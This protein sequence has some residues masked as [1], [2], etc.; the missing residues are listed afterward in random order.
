MNVFAKRYYKVWFVVLVVQ[1]VALLMYSLRITIGNLSQL[2]PP[3]LSSDDTTLSVLAASQQ[4]QLTAAASSTATKDSIPP[5]SI[6]VVEESDPMHSEM[7]TDLLNDTCLLRIASSIR[8][9]WTVKA[10]STWCSPTSSNNTTTSTENPSHQQQHKGLLLTKVPK[11]ASSTVAAIVLQIQHQWHCSVQWQH[12]RA[13]DLFY[14]QR[15]KKHSFLMAPVRD[16]K[17]RAMSSVYFH[18]ISFHQQRAD[19]TKI[20]SDNFIFN[21]LSKIPSNYI[22]DYLSLLHTPTAAEY[23][24]SF[25]PNNSRTI[26]AT[27][28]LHLQ[29]QKQSQHQLLQQQTAHVRQHIQTIVNEYD[30]LLVADQMVESLIVMSILTDIPLKSFVV[31]SSKVSGNWYYTNQR[32]IRLLSPVWT[33]PIVSYFESSSW[34][35][36]HILDRLLYMVAHHSLQATIAAH[37]ID[38][39]QRY[40]LFRTYQQQVQSICGNGGTNTTTLS[41]RCSDNGTV[42]PFPTKHRCYQRDFGCGYECVERALAGL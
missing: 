1:V 17:T 5:F 42:L 28:T 40:T 25:V 32:C 8:R 34:K 4:T 14:H 12:G 13:V 26:A 29:Q 7:C 21:Q 20:P 41:P 36:Q 11:S 37:R 39:E 18:T 35:Q 10:V 6:A 38:F 30:F 2:V 23:D 16:P 24:N 27:D 22:T 33:D 15:S 9:V 31:L 3:R 19:S